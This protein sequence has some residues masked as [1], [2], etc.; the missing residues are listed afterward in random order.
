MTIVQLSYIV[1]VDTYR[2][3]AT[4][5]EHC[6]VTQP[7][8]SMQIHK[9]EEEFGVQVFDRTKQ[10]IIP[11]DIGK[12]IIEQSRIVIR[13]SGRVH[14]IISSEMNEISGEFRVGIIPT[15]A[16]Y[17]IP[18]FLKRFREKYP[19]VELV[20]DEIQT[21]QII[22]KLDKDLLDVGIL[23]TPLKVEKF[24]ELPLYYEP[25]LAYIHDSHKLIESKELSSDD[26]SMDE[27]L[28]LDEGN[29]FRDQTLL[30]CNKFKENVKRQHIHFESGNLETLKKL[31]NQ[32]MGVSVLPS[33]MVNEFKQAEE[34]RRV[35]P[36]K[37][38]PRRE[39]SMIYGQC[40][41]KKHIID[42]LV[43][44][45]KESVPERYLSYEDGMRLDLN[46]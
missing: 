44:E 17:L 34:L 40:Y 18:L 41:L 20:I 42:V 37:I 23:A 45:I 26:L 10:P 1:A 46:I 25:L 12:K 29:C 35:K 33:L 21:N 27:M 9:L 13:E 8:L 16:P 31:V 2:H 30:L 4:A 39:I 19:K 7:T 22:D 5:A 38:E 32:E 24:T 43:E 14:D 6:F 3:F 11:T 15:V 28:L 36:F